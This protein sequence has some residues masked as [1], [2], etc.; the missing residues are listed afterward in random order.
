[1][2]RL[3][4]FKGAILQSETEGEHSPKRE[5]PPALTGGALFGSAAVGSL[6]AGHLVSS[7]D[8][9]HEERDPTMDRPTAAVA[10]P[11]PGA[12]SH[13]QNGRKSHKYINS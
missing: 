7:P 8:Q 2:A 4:I 13:G 11:K 6:A 1:M 10:R 12:A 5:W 9:V 3:Q